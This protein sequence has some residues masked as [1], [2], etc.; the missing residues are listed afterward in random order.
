[1]RRLIHAALTLLIVFSGQT[2][3]AAG[4]EQSGRHQSTPS[5]PFDQA[6]KHTILKAA[7]QFQRCYLD[8]LKGGASVRAGE[9]TVDWQITPKG[10]PVKTEI[11]SSSF[12]SAN[13]KPALEPC[14]VKHVATLEFPPTGKP[15]NHYTF[16][17]FRF[18]D[19]QQTASA[20]P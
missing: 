14:I 11:V 4:P 12:S 13:T 8:Y 6:V 1:M 20:T 2:L 9:L 5:D 16:H 19:V 7:G 18:K 10:K 17:K 3:F 15:E